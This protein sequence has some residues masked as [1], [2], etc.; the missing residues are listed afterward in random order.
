[1]NGLRT[2][3]ATA[4]RDAGGFLLPYATWVLRS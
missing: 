4:L 1:M 2:T 3:V